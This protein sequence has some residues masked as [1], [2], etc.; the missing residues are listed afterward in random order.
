VQRKPAACHAE[1]LRAARRH[2]KRICAQKSARYSG[3]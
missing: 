2:F 3:V 1:K